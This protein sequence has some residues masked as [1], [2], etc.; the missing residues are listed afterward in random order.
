MLKEAGLIA[1]QREGVY[2]WYRLA[3][4]LQEADNGFGP[5]WPL[6]KAHFEQT[7]GTPDG[8]ARAA[9][10]PGAELGGMGPR[11]RASPACLARRGSRVRRR[12]PDDRGEP[13]GLE[14]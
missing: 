6:L 14:S 9:A 7:A 10:R 8:R 12:L 4:R 13:V 5:L 2:T 11:A 3:P 1:E